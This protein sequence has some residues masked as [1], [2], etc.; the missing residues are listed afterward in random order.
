M[1]SL[2]SRFTD[3]VKAEWNHRTGAAD[4]KPS[5]PTATTEAR[6]PGS[7]LDARKTD[8]ESAW[9]VLELSPGATLDE[10]RAAHRALSQRYYPKTRSAEQT[11][12]NAAHTL[13]E[14]LADALFVLEEHLLP[15]APSERSR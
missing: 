9:R 13:L 10:V 6:T 15:V 12:A 14:A 7:A 11:Q 3:V 5:R 2:L 4:E 1:S 8:V